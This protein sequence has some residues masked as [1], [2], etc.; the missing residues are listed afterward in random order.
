MAWKD[1]VLFEYQ[2]SKNKIYGYLFCV[3]D[4]SFMRYLQDGPLWFAGLIPEVSLSVGVTCPVLFGV[5]D[6]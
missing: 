5:F 2:E 3:P 6:P 1:P 4:M